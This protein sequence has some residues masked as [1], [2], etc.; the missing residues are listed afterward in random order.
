MSLVSQLLVRNTQ[1]EEASAAAARDVYTRVVRQIYWL[2]VILAAAVA[3]AGVLNIAA[4]RRAFEE[5]RT[6]S[7][8]LRALS[9]RMLKLQEDVQTSMAR[10]LH[11]EFG[12]ILTAIT[13]CSA[14]SNAARKRMPNDDRR[15][16]RSCA[17]STR[18]TASRSRRSNA[19]ARSR[20]C[21]IRSSSTISASSRRSV[22]YV[23][24]FS[25]Q[26]GLPATFSTSGVGIVPPDIAIHIYRIV[27]EALG[28]ASR[29]ARASKAWVRLTQ[30]QGILTLEVEDD[31]RGLPQW[32]GEAPAGAGS[33]GS[34]AIGGIG[35][36]S[37]RERTELVGGELTL[38]RG[39]AGGLL[40][41]CVIPLK[42]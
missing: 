37:M 4:T 11:D 24:Q 23:D 17:T 36:T 20:A 41:R 5:V 1:V 6:L 26:H 7:G 32:R 29:H 8:Q 12:Q 14:A 10:E 31:G 25:R 38:V 39:A 9:W 33:G 19:S 40:I 21:S 42:L 16:I 2:M 27:Q 34:G 22:W 18:S 28:N 13:C 35:M 3:V 15:P 30:A